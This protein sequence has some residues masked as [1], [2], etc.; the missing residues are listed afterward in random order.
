MLTRRINLCCTFFP[1]TFVD[2]F[3]FC[4]FFAIASTNRH[5]QSSS[6]RICPC[7]FIYVFAE[8]AEFIVLCLFFI[9][10]YIVCNNTSIWHLYSIWISVNNI[11]ACLWNFAAFEIRK[12]ILMKISYIII[13]RLISLPEN[14]IIYN[15]FP[16]CTIHRFIKNQLDRINQVTVESLQS[17]DSSFS[18]YFIIVAR[19]CFLKSSSDI[20]LNSM[21]FILPPLMIYVSPTQFHMLS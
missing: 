1:S 15:F 16:T 13:I 14:F 2:H 20:N 7:I 5:A 9:S 8:D 4:D 19:T 3:I 18:P 21:P 17:Y 10:T 12:N 6:S 11:P